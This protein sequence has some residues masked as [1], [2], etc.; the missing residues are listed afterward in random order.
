[1]LA[2]ATR[3]GIKRE[4]PQEVESA[5]MTPIEIKQVQEKD[6]ASRTNLIHRVIMQNVANAANVANRE[7][8]G[9]RKAKQSS[10]SIYLRFNPRA[11]IKLGM[12][13]R[14]ILVPLPIPL[15]LKSKM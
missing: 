13:K 7:Y 8:K 6:F 5:T 2:A 10:A 4:M 15:Q 9:R 11:R 3:R 1:M 14:W 12:R